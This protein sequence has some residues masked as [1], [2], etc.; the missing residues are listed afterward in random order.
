MTAE[1]IARLR[2][3]LA[4]ADKF[5]MRTTGFDTDDLRAL[6]DARTEA[7]DALALFADSGHWSWEYRWTADTAPP[8]EI[9][10]A[11]LTKA[12]RR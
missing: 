8:F 4:V 2:E 3:K 1:A 9:A 11:V 6:L 12:G 7:L 10:R 5:H